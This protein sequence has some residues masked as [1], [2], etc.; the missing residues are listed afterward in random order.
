MFSTISFNLI[1]E[2]P[3]TLKELTGVPAI[4]KCSPG[5]ETEG[6]NIRNEEIFL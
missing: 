6:G 2:L 4:I 1:L 3:T 5:G